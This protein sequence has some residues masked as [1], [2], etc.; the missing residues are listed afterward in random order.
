MTK[1]AKP[2]DVLEIGQTVDAKITAIDD[3][4]KNVS[5]SIRELLE[6]AKALEEAMPEDEETVEA[7]EEAA[8]TAEADAE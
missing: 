2:A 8:E 5:L 7:V 3:E 4:K 6:E 1:I